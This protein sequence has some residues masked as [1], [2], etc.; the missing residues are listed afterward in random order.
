[1]VDFAVFW[2]VFANF[3]LSE[4]YSRTSCRNVPPR[5][6]ENNNFFPQEDA[7]YA[8]VNMQSRARYPRLKTFRVGKILIQARCASYI[9]RS[10]PRARTHR[11]NLIDAR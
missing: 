2:N 9:A 1:M 8:G 6:P 11:G 4:M 7:D 10:N 3:W 5:T